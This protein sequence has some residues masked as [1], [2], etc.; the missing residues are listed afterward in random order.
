MEWYRTGRTLR[1]IPAVPIADAVESGIIAAGVS[2]TLVNVSGAHNIT[3]RGLTFTETAM[4]TLEPYLVPSCG[5]WS[6]HANGALYVSG[7]SGL[8]VEGCSFVRTGGN[9]VFVHGRNDGTSISGCSFELTGDSAIAL[10]GKSDYIDGTAGDYPNNTLISTNHA[11]RL[12]VYGKQV[13]FVFQA[14]TARTTIE[15]NIAFDGPRAAVNFNDNFGGGSL[16]RRNLMFNWVKETGDHGV[17]NSWGRNPYL[18]TER[19]GS[20]SIVPAEHIFSSNFIIS[21]YSS[22]F[23]FDHDDG[24]AYYHDDANFL[25]YA[26]AK[27]LFGHSKHYTNNIFAYADVQQSY[28]KYSAYN[29]QASGWGDSGWDEWFIN[30]TVVLREGIMYSYQGGPENDP[31]QPQSPCNPKDPTDE[32]SH[33]WALSSGNRFYAPN[34]TVTVLCNTT[35]WDLYQFQ[36]AT[37]EDGGSTVRPLPPTAAI[38]KQARM[39]LGMKPSPSSSELEQ[40]DVL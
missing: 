21:N 34:S 25:V 19:F 35:V 39:L 9:G 7:S 36:A 6:I 37:G 22:I 2:K 29:S 10:L 4:T 12:G 27:N 13:S 20:A 3:L 28:G 26:P 17:F 15:D 24:S 11:S 31:D 5:D 32:L 23:P 18:T 38:M 40:K 14:L 30:N 33:P 16:M 8:A 1:Y